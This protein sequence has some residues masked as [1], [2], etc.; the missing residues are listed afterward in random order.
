MGCLI[1]FLE[2][3]DEVADLLLCACLFVVVFLGRLM[4][5][6]MSKSKRGRKKKWG[7]YTD[8]MYLNKRFGLN[9]KKTDTLGIASIVSL[10]DAFIIT[11]SLYISVNISDS[12]VIEMLVGLVV[13]V[14]LIL[15]T[16]EIIGRILLKKGYD[17]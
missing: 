1:V 12:I 6:K 9:P 11:I 10:L 4:L 15:I 17:K 14:M 2:R 8:I 16:N 13:V 3:G 7:T 5:Y